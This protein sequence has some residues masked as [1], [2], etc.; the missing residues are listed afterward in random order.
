M[1]LSTTCDIVGSQGLHL[2]HISCINWI[3]TEHMDVMT[4]I[5]GHV[6]EITEICENITSF[7]R[8]MAE[9]Q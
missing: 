8:G 3:H 9:V 2:D 5:A 4:S 1:G 7:M 6:E